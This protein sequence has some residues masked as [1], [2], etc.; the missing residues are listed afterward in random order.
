MSTNHWELLLNYETR[1]VMFADGVMQFSE[2]EFALLSYLMKHANRPITK[3]ELL[4]AIWSDPNPKS[5]NLV[6][7]T[8]RRV[9]VKLKKTQPILYEL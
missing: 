2:T 6:E 5:A 7:A 8:I 9:R 3:S 1:E 4:Q